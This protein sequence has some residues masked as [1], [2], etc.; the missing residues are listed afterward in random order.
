MTVLTGCGLVCGRRA[1]CLVLT[2]IAA[3]AIAG[4]ASASGH[5]S[6]PYSLPGANQGIASISC[7]TTTLCVAAAAVGNPSTTGTNDIFW[8]TN[9]KGGRASWHRVAL[10]RSVQPAIGGGQEEIITGV[11]CAKAGTGIHC[12]AADGF[13][14]FWQTGSPTSGHWSA[15]IPDSIGLLDVSCWSAA[16]AMLDANS[17]AVVQVGATIL[18]A[19]ANLF[20]VAQ[21]TSQG[22]IGCDTGQ[23]CAAVLVSHRVLWTS[24]ALASPPT[25]HSTS[26]RGG[27][28]LDTITCPGSHLCVATE[29][30]EAFQGWIGVWHPGRG[31]WQAVRMPAL[32]QSLY[33]ASCQ[34]TSFCV[35]T[36]SQGGVAGPGFILSSHHPAAK[37]S[38]WKRGAVPIPDPAVVS[39]ASPSLCVVGDGQ[40]GKVSVGHP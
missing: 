7:P 8:T 34:S 38:A 4:N 14:N 9:P 28:D 15:Q 19:T 33:S 22:S 24:N 39:C 25:W 3:L 5:W 27:R 13:A 36:G 18:S 21:T 12:G 31:N 35:V 6:K 17:G 32:D 29:G 11:S 23:F 37:V 16:C 40:D 20:H 10:E 26:V 30:E 1:L 2:L